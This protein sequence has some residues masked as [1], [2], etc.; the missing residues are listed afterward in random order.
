MWIF[1]DIQRDIGRKIPN[2]I[3]CQEVEKWQ[4]LIV[5]MWHLVEISE[6]IAV[7]A[8][9]NASIS[10]LMN[11]DVSKKILSDLVRK[12]VTEFSDDFFHFQYATREMCKGVLNEMRFTILDQTLTNGVLMVGQM[13]LHSM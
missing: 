13:V 3:P 1:V 10:D 12:N 7:Y 4:W 8:Y 6:E 9:R 11:Q 5:S 2:F